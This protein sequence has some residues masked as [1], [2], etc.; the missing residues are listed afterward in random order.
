MPPAKSNDTD[1]NQVPV[2][3][4]IRRHPEETVIA[5]GNTYLRQ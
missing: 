1:S 2:P 4:E 5:G 3:E